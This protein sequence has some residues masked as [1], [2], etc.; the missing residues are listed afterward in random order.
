LD[1]TA[2]DHKLEPKGQQIEKNS[3]GLD[4][5]NLEQRIDLE[6]SIKVTRLISSILTILVPNLTVTNHIKPTATYLLTKPPH[7]AIQHVQ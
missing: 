5:K 7:K 4:K 2:I 1:N 3:N 6:Q